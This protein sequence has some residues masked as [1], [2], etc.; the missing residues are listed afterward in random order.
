M[1]DDTDVTSDT[2]AALRASLTAAFENADYPVSNQMAL[3]PALP[4]GPT[5]TFEAGETS[6]TAME[7]AS[8]LSG[9]QEFPYDDV[10]S[11]VDD[12]IEGLK[13]EGEL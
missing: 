6:F 7:L 10:G 11:L 12:V 5:T 9:Y 8:K 13:A 3:V 4:N 1:T 2:E